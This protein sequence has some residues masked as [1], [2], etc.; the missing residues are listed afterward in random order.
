VKRSDPTV[1]H[2]VLVFIAPAKTSAKAVVSHEQGSPVSMTGI[3][4]DVGVDGF[5]LQRHGYAVRV[6]VL[7]TTQFFESGVA[8]PSFVDVTDGTALG[9]TAVV[10]P[11]SGAAEPLLDADAVYIGLPAI[12]ALG[13]GGSKPDGPTGPSG[14]SGATTTTSTPPHTVKV[15]LPPGGAVSAITPSSFVYTLGPVTATVMI[16]PSTIFFLGDATTSATS[17]S[18]PG[19]TAGV[20]GVADPQ[21]TDGNEI[22]DA[23]HVYLAEP[24]GSATS[25]SEPSNTEPRNT[26][27]PT[28]SPSTSEP[29]NGEPTTSQ[30]SGG[31]PGGSSSAEPRVELP[32]GGTASDITATSFVYTNGSST[33][34]VKIEPTTLFFLGN[35]SATAASLG[36]AGVTVGVAGILDPSSTAAALVVDALHVYLTA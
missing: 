19:I 13:P 7:A 22:V 23:R 30:P 10:D 14:A 12:G 9:V 6:K 3:A 15:E 31:A 20:A 21:S 24:G 36:G 17:L 4:E 16:E 34:T 11:S 26:E 5:T 27:P 18:L 1:I 29:S 25:T 32:P 2:A 8:S 33:A 28:S 35:A